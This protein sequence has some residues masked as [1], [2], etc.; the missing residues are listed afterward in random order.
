MPRVHAAVDVVD[1]VVPK[2]ADA[3]R[4]NLGDRA[5]V[6]LV[7]LALA[8]PEDLEARA[9]GRFRVLDRRGR[10]LGRLDLARQES[11]GRRRAQVALDGGVVSQCARRRAVG[12]QLEL[13][14][15]PD[16][17][18]LGHSVRRRVVHEVRGVVDAHENAVGR[19]MPRA[20]PA[21]A[22][23]LVLEPDAFRAEDVRHHPILVA[24]VGHLSRV[25]LQ[26][27]RLAHLGRATHHQ[28]DGVVAREGGETSYVVAQVALRS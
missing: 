20:F 5:H 11:E 3:R 1:N 2:L 17:R 15:A 21:G 27:R 22:L 26:S 16:E 6:P 25:A 24:E 8:S 10:C 4:V 9:Y 28:I 18:L 12:G 7:R 19:A 13:V 23:G 14:E